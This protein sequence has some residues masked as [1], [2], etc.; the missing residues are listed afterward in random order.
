MSRITDVKKKHDATI[1]IKNDY[2]DRVGRGTVDLADGR[3]LE[4][5]TDFTE[6]KKM[7]RMGNAHTRLLSAVQIVR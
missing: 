2:G 5:E 4:G 1:K 7:D 3:M 6:S